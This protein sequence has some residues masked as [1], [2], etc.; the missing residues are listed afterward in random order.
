MLVTEKGKTFLK[1]YL[2]DF[3]TSLGCGADGPKA[4][5]ISQ[6]NMFDYGEVSKAYLALGLWEKPWQKRW[7]ENGEK[8]GNSPAVGYF[9]NRRF[10][11]EEFKTQLPYYAFKDTTNADGF[12]AAKIIMSFSDD[13]IR[14][15]VKAGRLKS[16]EDADYI[17]KTLIERRDLIGRYWFKAANPLDGFLLEGDRLTFKDLSVDYQF[18][19]KQSTSYRVDVF[20][21]RGS[22][23]IKIASVPLQEPAMTIDPKW[24][25]GDQKIDLYF[26]TVRTQAVKHNPY[27]LVSLDR[28]GIKGVIHQD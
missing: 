24:I 14:A 5:M 9:D 23:R 20:E 28:T 26:Y 13:D 4:P 25:S 10:D 7:R 1:H 12:W 22:Q 17:A 15:A 18:E 11:A 21:I 3:N 2:L 16:Q 27:V 19:N 8:V 6:E